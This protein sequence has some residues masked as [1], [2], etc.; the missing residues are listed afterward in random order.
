M[1]IIE[2]SAVEWKAGMNVEMVYQKRLS[3]P[4]KKDE[5]FFFLMK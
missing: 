4:R 2:M 5:S 1:I 3:A